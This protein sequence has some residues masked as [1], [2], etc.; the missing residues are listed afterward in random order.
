MEVKKIVEGMTAPQVAQVIDDNFKN[1]NKIL[2]EDIAKQNSV[3]GVSEYKDFSEAEAVNVGDVRKYN[4][5]L[6]ECVEATT[7][8]FDARKWKKSSFKDETEKKL[9]ELGKEMFLN[10][11]KS[12]SIANSGYMDYDKVVNVASG[13]IYAGYVNS[14]SWDTLWVY[15]LEGTEYIS[16]E[17]I[18][19]GSF[20]FFSEISAD[21]DYNLGSN[22]T[23]E[24]IEGAK[25][26][27]VTIKKSD[28]PNGYGNLK[29]RQYNGEYSKKEYVDKGLIKAG[30]NVFIDKNHHF[31]VN[32]GGYA[33]SSTHHSV[34]VNVDEG[35]EAIQLNEAVSDWYAM[36][37]SNTISSTTYLGG[38]TSGR[39][40]K[41]GSKIV[42]IS[43]PIA[44]NTDISDISVKLLGNKGDRPSSRNFVV[45]YRHL[46][47]IAADG[48]ASYLKNNDYD[49]LWV[50]LM[51]NAKTIKVEGIN[52]TRAAYYKGSEISDENYLGTNNTGNVIKGAT[53]CIINF[54][55][56]EEFVDYD[57]VTVVQKQDFVGN[58][59]FSNLFGEYIR[60]IPTGKNYIDANN[61]LKGK[62]LSGGQIINS[63]NGIMSNKIYLE[64]GKTYTMQGI[65]YYGTANKIYMAT[66]DKKDNHIGLI[67]VAA[68]FPEF[69]STHMGKGTFKFNSNYG[70]IS[71]VRII[72]QGNASYP[73]DASIAQ[74][75]EGETATEVVPYEGEERFLIDFGNNNNENPATRKVVRLLSIGNSYSEDSLSYVP[76]IIKNMGVNVDFQIGILMMSSSNLGNHIDN[77]TNQTAAYQFYLFDKTNNWRR[78]TDNASFPDSENVSIQWALDSYKWD[79]IFPIGFGTGDYVGNM[80]TLINLVSSY[81][82]YPIK[83][84]VQVGYIRPSRANTGLDPTTTSYTEEEMTQRYEE[85]LDKS[86]NLMENTV[87]EIIVPIATA[88]K[89]ACSVPTI[90]VLGEFSTFE[91]NE[92]PTIDGVPPGYLAYKD[93]V[94]LQEG[95]PCQIAAYTFVRVLLDYYGYKELSIIGESTRVTSEWVIGKGIPH[96]HGEPIGSTDENCLVAQKSVIMAVKNPYQIIDM[97]EKGLV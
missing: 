2:E 96:A 29:V 4:G 90:K 71:Y 39:I 64:D 9:S 28:N 20:R 41:A 43:L 14:S 95:L 97:T 83:W 7:G 69:D 62:I 87:C 11:L 86:K 55:R 80:N 32:T 59:R 54:K 44:D 45:A 76:Y 8:A 73:F 40:S 94:H 23:G 17:G 56:P 79:M 6:Y 21:K 1:Q 77:F 26:C 67:S 36:F 68:E 63:A 74:L 70:A 75:E 25:V 92:L 89:N 72:L 65:Y 33:K 66:Y 60:E 10:K 22:K 93:G 42:I 58:E 35:T 84:G 88:I 18:T 37:S 78:I 13:G 85:I 31:D 24:V 16:V 53:F 12:E 47:N 27:L 61:L 50:H 19:H 91:G 30:I 15:L 51:D 46:I 3:I 81:V 57:N 49:C 48:K 52:A 5:F 82:N 38:N 34:W